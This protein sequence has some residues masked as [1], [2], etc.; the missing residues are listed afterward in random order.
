[1]TEKK[2]DPVLLSQ[3][4]AF[5]LWFQIRDDLY[6]VIS[7]NAQKKLKHDDIL[8]GKASWLLLVLLSLGGPASADYKEAKAE[9]NVP[10]CATLLRQVCVC[11]FFFLCSMFFPFSY[12]LCFS[13]FVTCDLCV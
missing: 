11:P 3:A 1:M 9:D 8:E 13:V 4:E 2:V 10:K 6:N 5:G 7:K 12:L